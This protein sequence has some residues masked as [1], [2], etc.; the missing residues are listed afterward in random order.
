[1]ITIKVNGVE[2]S[3]FE[4]SSVTSSMETVSS[5]FNFSA[6][7]QPKVSYPIKAGDTVT[8]GIDGTTRVTGFVEK[9]SVSYSADSHTI[10]LQGR[11]RLADLIDSTVGDTKQVVAPISLSSI[12]RIILDG[13]GLSDVQVIDNVGTLTD[14]SEGELL[15]ASVGEKAFSFLEKFARTKQALLTTDGLGNLVIER[16]SSEKLLT[17]LINVPGN[18][19]SNILTGSSSVDI[20]QRY[21]LYKCRADQNLSSGLSEESMESASSQEGEAKDDSIRSS[22]ILEFNSEENSADGTCTDRA[23]WEANVRRARSINASLVVPGNSANGQLW[24]PNRLVDVNDEFLNINAQMLI[25][26][27]TYSQSLNQGSTTKL[28]LITPDA[29][30]LE[31]NQSPVSGKRNNVSD[32]F[33]KDL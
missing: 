8:V 10:S 1:M 33:L 7:A 3:G 22:R 19:L 9:V 12:C 31:A 18:S 23:I 29:Y 14:F 2:L 11:D 26:S 24:I 17:Q 15:S 30:K 27:V 21:N 16:G 20:S 4:S 5:S 6:T 13:I 28:D 32:N 25:K